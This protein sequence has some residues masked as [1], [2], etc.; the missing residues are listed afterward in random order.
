MKTKVVHEHRFVSMSVKFKMKC[1]Y[2][3]SAALEA[4]KPQCIGMYVIP[5]FLFSLL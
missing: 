5:F 3:C 1:W 2:Y 4:P